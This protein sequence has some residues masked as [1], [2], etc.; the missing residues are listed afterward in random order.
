M[1]RCLVNKITDFGLSKMKGMTTTTHDISSSDYTPA[2]TVLYI[3]HEGYSTDYNP[4]AELRMKLDI[5]RWVMC[6]VTFK[7]SLHSIVIPSKAYSSFVL[8][9]A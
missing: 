3:A 7:F 6:S 4:T 2:G 5:Y 8:V 9:L 1:S